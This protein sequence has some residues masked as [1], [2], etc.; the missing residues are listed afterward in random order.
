MTTRIFT[1]ILT[2]GLRSG[3]IPERTKEAREWYRQT[4]RTY[5]A[6]VRQGGTQAGRIDYLRINERKFINEDSSRL[7]AKIKPGDMYMFS[8]SAKYADELPY[9]DRFPL[10]FPFRVAS[11]RFWGLNLHYL[12]LPNRAIVMDQLYNF[13]NNSRFDESTKLRFSYQMLNA[14]AKSHM[15]KPCVKQYLFSHLRT[16]FAYIYPY[17]WSICSFLPLERFTGKTKAQVHAD[18]NRQ[19]QR[20]R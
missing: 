20:G 19:I 3:Q 16:Q 7:V 17:E 1:D 8:Y 18:T 12:S 13:K 5:G 10:I 15:F 4:A 9:W 11:D 2:Q 14:A 6:T